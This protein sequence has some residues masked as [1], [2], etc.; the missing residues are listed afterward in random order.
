MKKILNLFFIIGFIL[1]LTNFV[2]AEQNYKLEKVLILSRHNLRAPLVTKDSEIGQMTP[3]NWF[4][5]Q[6]KAGEL[7]LKGAL[8]ETSMGQYFRLYL[9]DENF[10]PANYIPKENEVRFY[11]NSFQRTIATAQYFSAA[12]FPVADVNVEYKFGVNEKD[13]IFLA[14]NADNYNTNYFKRLQAEKEKSGGVERLKKKMSSYAKSTEKILDFKNSPYAKQNHLKN[15]SAADF[16][17]GEN[18]YVEGNLRLAMRASDALIMQYYETKNLFGKKLTENDLKNITNA[19]YFGVNLIFEW[20]T[21]ATAHINPMLILMR[22]EL[23]NTDR[24]FTFLCGHDVTLAMV[25]SALGVESYN[26][27]D[28]LEKMTPLG[29]KLVIE[30]RLGADGKNYA[31]VNLVYQS[32]SQIEN[33]DVLD[34][35][36]PPK[37]FTLKFKNL[38]A[39]SD[40]LYLYS[41]FEKILNQAIAEYDLLIEK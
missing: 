38:Q 23:S 17:I 27:P 14:S 36:N 25:L 28:S 30:K 21:W 26:L 16:N 35:N 39:N 37:I 29:A 7:S 10:F 12:L 9:A 33:V 4:D 31:K 18:P 19:S 13:P 2:Y 11:A 6:V 5:W 1:S 32:T 3:H 24:K 15:F 41:D 40:G 20:R 8:L 22:D 34:L